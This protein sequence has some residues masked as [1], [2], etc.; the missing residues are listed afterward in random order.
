MPSH[1]TQGGKPFG[2]QRLYNIANQHAL[3]I[4]FPA[5][6]IA[7]RWTL[8][9]GLLEQGLT[10]GDIQLIRGLDRGGSSLSEED[11]TGILLQWASLRFTSSIRV[12]PL[13]AK[14][15]WHVAHLM[16]I[17]LQLTALRHSLS[18]NQQVVPTRCLSNNL[19]PFRDGPQSSVA[20]S[21]ADAELPCFVLQ[22]TR[23]R[24]MFE[25]PSAMETLEQHFRKPDTLKKK[26]PAQ[27][28][29]VP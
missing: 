24:Y 14:K 7:A 22:S 10:P 6:Y 16:D 11:L 21:D 26:K 15:C 28:T 27:N 23:L 20:L 2:T 19:T 9:K 4:D 3:V 29:F 5:V 18:T 1:A 13:L 25:I 12:L 17:L 8:A